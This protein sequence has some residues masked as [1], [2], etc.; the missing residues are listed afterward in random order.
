MTEKELKSSDW[1]GVSGQQFQLKMSK[2]SYSG[3]IN[4]GGLNLKVVSDPV[5]ERRKRTSKLKLVKWWWKVTGRE[6]ENVWTYK[7][8]IV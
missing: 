7:V 6:Y 5:Q 4:M 8:K 3:H 2:S 1:I